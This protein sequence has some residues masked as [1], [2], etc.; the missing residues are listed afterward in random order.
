MI[1][2][3]H[4]EAFVSVLV[5]FDEECVQVREALDVLGI[6]WGGE[7]FVRIV[8]R[9]TFGITR[10]EDTEV[11]RKVELVEWNLMQGQ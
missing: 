11:V 7:G 8:L 10:L 2:D 9:F 1:D 4:V 3:T 5:G 6:W